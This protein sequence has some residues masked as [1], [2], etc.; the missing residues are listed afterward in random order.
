MLP[1]FFCALINTV[2]VNLSLIINVK[3]GKFIMITMETVKARKRYMNPDVY[4][5]S[6]TNPNGDGIS[7]NFNRLMET[8]YSRVVAENVLRQLPK[9]DNSDFAF[10][11]IL[12]VFD[13]VCTH[14]NASYINTITNQIIESAVPKTRTGAETKDYLKMKVARFK[15]K[16]ST[17]INNRI[18]NIKDAAGDITDNMKKNLST[19]TAGIRGNVSKVVTKKDA[20][21]EEMILHSYERIYQ[22]YLESIDCDRIIQN[23]AKLEKFYNLRGV[24]ETY[25]YDYPQAIVE[26]CAM[27]DSFNMSNP[28]KMNTS[29]ESTLYTFSQCNI[30][31]PRKLVL[32]TVLDYYLIH[33]NPLTESAKTNIS[34][35]I[36]MNNVFS[37]DDK[38]GLD[39]TFKDIA[40]LDIKFDDTFILLQENPDI[41]KYVSEM[42][43]LNQLMESVKPP[44]KVKI[45]I[46]KFKLE[47]TKTP[48][49]LREL[50]YRMYVQSPDQILESLPNFLSWIRMFFVVGGGTAINPIIGII[51][52]IA[53]QALKI[54]LTRKQ[55]GKY[56]KD[57]EKELEKATKALDSAKDSETKDRLTKYK[58]Q[59]ETSLDK[60]RAKEDSVYTDDENYDRHLNDDGDD[61]FDFNFDESF[62]NARYA[63]ETIAEMVTAYDCYNLTETILDNFD[64]YDG[65]SISSIT[66]CLISYPEIANN[67]LIANAFSDYLSK[68]TKGPLTVESVDFRTAVRESAKRLFVTAELCPYIDKYGYSTALRL[69]NAIDGYNAIVEYTAAVTT[70]NEMDFSNTM[71][72]AKERL[73]STITGLSDKEKSM[74]RTVDVACDQVSRSAEKA[75]VNGNREAVIRG[76]LLP[77]ASKIIKTAIVSGAAWAINPAAAVIGVLG[78]LGISKHLQAKERQLILDDIEIEINMCERY[79]KIA[80]DNN[81][82]AAQ[83]SLLMTKR[84]LDRQRQR[85]KYKMI[86]YHNQKV[87]A[88]KDN[89]DDDD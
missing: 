71:K 12:E 64:K 46:D 35:V 83:R 87:D 38:T 49:K 76:S 50:V 52:L 6:H 34:K 80:E 2:A 28:V 67:L 79:L 3:G 75:L 58:K 20:Q 56:V 73:K 21:R 44:N 36:E 51:A 72:M 31:V 7:A 18:G 59:V 60:L 66:D 85:I 42:D 89:S 65:D 22:A 74:S 24:V 4:K 19:N 26:I 48:E 82:M 5:E 62:V 41:S 23:Q 8:G 14:E 57:Y 27:I 11:Q 25:Y 1:L 29:L 40:K 81:D 10:R 45:L 17:K 77:S 78:A 70:L 55:L 16:L 15:T 47:A 13:M 63:L 86:V 43:L 30:N 37:D 9:Y 39:V 84:S 68:S 53:D 54:T 69:E 32:E 33:T 88:K 61:L